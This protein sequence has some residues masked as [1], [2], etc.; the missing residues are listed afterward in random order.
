MAIIDRV[1]EFVYETSFEDI[2][3]ETV[4][5]TKLLCSKIV[6]AMLSGATTQAGRKTI[7]H[8][9][10]KGCKGESG[11]IGAGARTSLEDAVFVNGITSHAAELEDDQFPSAASDITVFPVIFPLAENGKLTGRELLGASALGMEVMTRLGM[12]TLSSKGITDLPFYG[13]I[14]AAI[15]AGKALN[16][17]PPRLKSAVGISLGRASGY[18]INFG[19]DAHYIESAA[20][21]RDGLMA[22]Q[23]AKQGMTG[24]TDVEKWVQDVCTGLPFDLD[25]ITQGLGQ[26]PWH[27][28]GIW[29]KKYPCCFL[30]HR[31]ID[32]MLEFLAETNVSYDTIEKIVIHVGPVDNT[33][34]RPSPVDTE[35]ARFSFHHIMAALML[36]NDIDSYH[37]TEEKIHDPRFREGWT[38]VSVENHLD[39]PA[40]FMSGDA[41]IEV[42]LADGKS[43]VRE[44]RQAKG[45]PE[46]PLG[47]EEFRQLYR[48]YTRNVLSHEDMDR[49]WQMLTDLEKI[50]ELDG[51]LS[52]LFR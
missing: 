16:L 46:F 51:F 43:I 26:R 25:R 39:W 7:Q 31:H 14:G 12:F 28:H 6:A 17:S 13:V 20:A 41:K 38:K 1:A 34:N 10:S 40:E 33:C 35:D 11:V 37:F 47:L 18:I 2:P 21:C 24:G 5:Y 30:T 4:T 22:A 8:V 36:D 29:V 42:L 44:R 32:M 52:Y 23:L 49:T 9:E 45:A 15:T 27:M 3:N 48:K 19:T 50:D